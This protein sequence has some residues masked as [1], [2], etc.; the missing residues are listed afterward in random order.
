M[1]VRHMNWTNSLAQVYRVLFARKR[2]WRLNKFLFLLSLRGLGVLNYENDRVSGEDWFLNHLAK[3]DAFLTIFD[4]GANK[5]RYS[6]SVRTVYPNSKVYAFEPHP[7]TFQVLKVVAEKYNFVPLNLG[8]S[9]VAGTFELYDYSQ[10]SNG[11]EHASLYRDV[12]EQTHKAPAK[13]WQIALTTVD[14]FVEQHNINKIDLLKIDTEG[15]EFRVLRGAQAL[16]NAGRITNIHFEFNE[17]NVI[18]RVFFKDFYEELPQY[19]FYRMLP[20]G[21]VPLK[22]YDPLSQEI[23]AFQNIV[24]VHS[25][26]S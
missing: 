25:G 18:S 16:I 14:D 8:C 5:G 6:Q 22:S 9:D 4:V 20:D 11:S 24:A 1:A 26:S 23:F 17:M 3:K 19:A 7:T 12:I 13:S 21:V 10:E 15:N 2:F